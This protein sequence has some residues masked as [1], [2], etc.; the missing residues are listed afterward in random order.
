M[1]DESERVREIHDA[2]EKFDPK[3][4][5]SFKYLQVRRDRLCNQP[6]LLSWRLCVG[7]QGSEGGRRPVHAGG[8]LRTHPPPCVRIGPHQG[9]H[10]V[11]QRVCARI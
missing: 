7:E 3:A 11:R 8:R 2:A 10:R 6:S 5:T 9:L 4:E 1:L